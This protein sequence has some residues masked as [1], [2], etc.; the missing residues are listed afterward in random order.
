[1]R[2]RRRRQGGENGHS[3]TGWVKKTVEGVTRGG[4]KTRI[5]Q[6]TAEKYD[7]KGCGVRKK[8]AGEKK[9]TERVTLRQI[10]STE[11]G[12]HRHGGR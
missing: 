11:T 8:A 1:M 9:V 3:V 4:E 10:N 7:S 12:V 6:V 2:G 5:K